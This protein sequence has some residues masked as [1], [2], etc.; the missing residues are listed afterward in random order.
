MANPFGNWNRP[1]LSRNQK[2]DSGLL[3]DP[4]PHIGPVV[5]HL[6]DDTITRYGH[7]GRL[8]KFGTGKPYVGKAPIA[9]QDTRRHGL[10]LPNL[11]W[12]PDTNRLERDSL[13]KRMGSSFE[14]T[15]PGLGF[16]GTDILRIVK[17]ARD[18]PFSKDW[19]H[20]L[21]IMQKT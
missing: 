9:S 17:G 19:L 13:L 7:L 15:I 6:D 5:D 14:R 21:G 2:P 3:V 16:T 12:N 8:S 20:T 18:L 10:S 11:V 1:W 4:P